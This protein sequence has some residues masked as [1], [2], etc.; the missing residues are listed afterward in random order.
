MGKTING[1][2]GKVRRYRGKETGVAKMKRAAKKKRRK[3]K[4]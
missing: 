1:G 4:K 3:K 2:T